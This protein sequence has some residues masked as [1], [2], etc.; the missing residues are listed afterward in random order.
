[1]EKNLM[2]EL[3]KVSVIVPCRNE[4][5]YIAACL[6]TILSNSYPKDKM[7]I[8]VVDGLSEDGT[9]DILNDLSNKYK[10]IRII[11][12]PKRNIPT[13]MNLGIQ[14]AKGDVIMKIDAHSKYDSEYIIKCV[15]YQID[16][17]ADNVGG[18]VNII[19]REN[20]FISKSIAKVLVQP[21]GS[22]NAYIKIGSEKPRWSDSA[23]VGCF[24]REVFEKLGLFDENLSRGSDMDLN[25]RIIKNGGKIL[26][27]PEIITNYYCDANFKSFWK[28]NY[29]DGVW[30]THVIKYG[31]MAFSFRH[32]VPLFFVANIIF[33]P[34]LSLFFAPFIWLFLSILGIYLFV[35]VS[36]TAKMYFSEKDKN[37]RYLYLFPW[38]FIIRHFSHGLGAIYGLIKL[39]DQYTAK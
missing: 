19:P 16:Y 7:E 30:T 9:R 4:I 12:N 24:R 1:M 31:S 29:S 10:L 17:K 26:L 14:Q 5:K 32:L 36:V 11:D 33:L 37:I 27:V 35:V 21:F 23:F 3:P 22:G 25:K 38:A 20:T 15:K 13:A 8:I 28:H 39:K 6:D 18:I 34:F 2:N